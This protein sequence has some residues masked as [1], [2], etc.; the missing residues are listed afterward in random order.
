[1]NNTFAHSRRYIASLFLVATAT[2]A[3]AC[4]RTHEREY[5]AATAYGLT[6]PQLRRL[7]T[8]ASRRDSAAAMRIATYYLFFKNDTRAS[9]YWL[10]VAGKYGD[11][12]AKKAA[13]KLRHA[14]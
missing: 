1:M 3:M 5:S 12:E 9:L 4:V 8:L 11:K 13:W 14:D 10:D 7:E 2:F 6:T